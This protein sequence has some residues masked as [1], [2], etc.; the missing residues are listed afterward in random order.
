MQ[1]RDIEAQRAELA[2][3]KER[4]SQLEA[5]RGQLR[6]VEHELLL[7]TGT[8]RHVRCAE[9]VQL[10]WVTQSAEIQTHD[11]STRRSASGRGYVKTRPGIWP[12]FES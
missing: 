5:L 1:Q 12:G 11:G 10:S 2:I 4:L 8:E 3:V 6:A 9:A 7:L